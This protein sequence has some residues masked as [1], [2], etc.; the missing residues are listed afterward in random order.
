MLLAF[1]R[2]PF[3]C[4]IARERAGMLAESCS[5]RVSHPKPPHKAVEVSAI[6]LGST[7]SLAL[8][9]SIAVGHPPLWERWESCYGVEGI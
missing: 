6:G 4:W 2:C 3:C 1:P 9:L 7:A 5:R 8:V